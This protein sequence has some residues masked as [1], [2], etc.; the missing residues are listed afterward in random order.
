MANEVKFLSTEEVLGK[1]E[2]DP[3]LLILDVRTEPEWEAHHIPGATWIPMHT[4]L[5]RLHEL[6]QKRET[7]VV[8][9][10]GV[11]SHNVAV[12]LATDAAFEDVATMEGGMSEWNGPREYGV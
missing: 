9:E 6:D 1:R 10:H 2:A 7:I 8:C 4:L 11:R 12:Y 5:E 3:M